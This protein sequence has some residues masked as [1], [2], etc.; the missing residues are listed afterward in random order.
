MR[1]E[2]G[3]ARQRA[4]LTAGGRVEQGGDEAGSHG[5]GWWLVEGLHAR[6][7]SLDFPM[8]NKKLE[9]VLEQESR[10]E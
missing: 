8:G 10:K 1:W 3:K 6:V 7:W 2:K 9:K 5:P 4:H